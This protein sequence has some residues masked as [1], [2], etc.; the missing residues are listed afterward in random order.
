MAEGA[1]KDVV[2]DTG[3]SGSESE[4][5]KISKEKKEVLSEAVIKSKHEIS[6]QSP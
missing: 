1:E 6:A 2:A 3:R 4:P 5:T